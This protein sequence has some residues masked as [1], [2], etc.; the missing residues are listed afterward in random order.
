MVLIRVSRGQKVGPIKPEL[1][2]SVLSI[3]RLGSDQ[4]E[5]WIGMNNIDFWKHLKK[6]FDPRNLIIYRN[7]K[8][9]MAPHLNKYFLFIDHILWSLTDQ[10]HWK[11]RMVILPASK[12]TY[13]CQQTWLPKLRPT[14]TCQ[15][16]PRQKKNI[17]INFLAPF[18]S[19]V[20]SS[21]F[22]LIELAMSDSKLHVLKWRLGKLINLN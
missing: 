9:N 15:V 7:I 6:I 8:I 14:T 19:P 4:F 13:C 11:T 16:W 10:C 2:W 5:L 12:C 1:N 18:Y 20:N 21:I 22:C 17:W 3:P